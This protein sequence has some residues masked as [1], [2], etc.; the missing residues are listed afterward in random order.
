MSH[1]E[2]FHSVF[3]ECKCQILALLDVPAES[4]AVSMEELLIQPAVSLSHLQAEWM[5]TL[6]MKLLESEIYKF[7]SFPVQQLLQITSVPAL[8]GCQVFHHPGLLVIAQ[9]MDPIMQVVQVVVQDVSH[10]MALEPMH[11]MPALQDTCGL[12][13][14]AFLAI[15]LAL[16][17]LGQIMINVMLVLADIIFGMGIHA[18]LH[19]VLH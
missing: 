8:P 3:G 4:Q 10:A 18:L 5:K 19:A 17:A 15:L 11:A 14:I 1:L 12:V 2:A 16:Y 6:V 9:T 13:V 7:F